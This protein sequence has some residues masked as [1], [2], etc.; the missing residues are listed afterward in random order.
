MCMGVSPA[1]MSTTHMVCLW[2]Q[3]GA[4]DYMGLGLQ[5]IVSSFLLCIKFIFLM[6]F[7]HYFFFC[8]LHFNSTSHRLFLWFPSCCI[9]WGF[10]NP[11]IYFIPQIWKLYRHHFFNKTFLPSLCFS[12]FFVELVTEHYEWIFIGQFW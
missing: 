10:M 11:C 4:L 6:Q 1:Y 3:K 8:F 12:P 7:S 2:R 9:P 5:V